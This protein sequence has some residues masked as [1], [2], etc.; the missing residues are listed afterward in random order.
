[1]QTWVEYQGPNAPRIFPQSYK[2]Y[3]T[4]VWLALPHKNDSDKELPFPP[5]S[6][7]NFDLN[8]FIDEN[9]LHAP[10]AVSYF[11]SGYC[12]KG[13]KSSLREEFSSVL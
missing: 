1:M 8:Q 13:T 9:N 5:E 4:Y 6:T 10:T 3:Y 12:V 7:T 11:V 2:F